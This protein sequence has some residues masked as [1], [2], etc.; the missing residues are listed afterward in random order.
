M[1]Y[2]DILNILYQRF[3]LEICYKIMSYMEHPTAVILKHHGYT[4]R[5]WNDI[6]GGNFGVFADESERD[7]DGFTYHMIYGQLGSTAGWLGGWVDPKIRD[8]WLMK[9]IKNCKI[10]NERFPTMN[11][12]VGFGLSAEGICQH[13]DYMYGDENYNPPPF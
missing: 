4:W 1:N 3:P 9:D 12:E 5:R 13:C 2:T 6:I 7:D 11:G 8:G 10:C